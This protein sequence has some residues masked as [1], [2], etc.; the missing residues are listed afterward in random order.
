M[1]P[2][3]RSLISRCDMVMYTP[4]AGMIAPRGLFVH[5]ASGPLSGPFVV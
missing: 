4:Q 1:V 3:S 5:F 2:T